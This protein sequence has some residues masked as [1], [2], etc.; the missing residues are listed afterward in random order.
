MSE[1]ESRIVKSIYPRKSYG[2]DRQNR[3][4]WFSPEWGRESL[5]AHGV[6][7]S[8]EKYVGHNFF[9]FL[10]G[11]EA[12]LVYQ[13]LFQVLRRRPGP[14]LK[15]TLRCDRMDA[16][17]ILILDLQSHEHEELVV[18]LDYVLI[19]PYELN[20]AVPQD[21]AAPL[22]MC[23]WCQDIFAEDSKEWLPIERALGDMFVLQQLPIPSF[24][25]TCCTR[26][27]KII[28]GKAHAYPGS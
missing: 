22:R 15:L 27:V 4:L 20:S 5:A 11:P 26:C 21:W 9:D 18:S 6:E 19:D 23:S 24:T 25:H 8:R 14:G 10:S 28:R 3:F 1:L 2:L 7:F 16:K 17:S 13:A 12:K